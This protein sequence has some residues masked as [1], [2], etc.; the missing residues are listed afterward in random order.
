MFGLRSSQN[1]RSLGRGKPS[2]SDLNEMKDL[3]NHPAIKDSTLA[4]CP[5]GART[6]EKTM[7]RGTIVAGAVQDCHHDPQAWRIPWSGCIECE[8]MMDN[9]LMERP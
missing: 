2:E 4:Q 6:E 5:L 8:P 3:C 1:S 7:L 9:T